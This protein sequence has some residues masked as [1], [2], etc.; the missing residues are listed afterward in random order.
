MIQSWNDCEQNAIWLWL[1]YET[2]L[3]QLWYDCDII[4]RWL[5][6]D[7]DMIMIWLWYDYDMI[8]ILIWNDYDIIMK[9]LWYDTSMIV[10]WLSFWYD[11]DMLMTA[12]WHDSWLWYA[13]HMLLLGWRSL[14]ESVSPLSSSQLAAFFSMERG[15]SF[16]LDVVSRVT[17]PPCLVNGMGASVESI[18]NISKCPL[19]VCRS[20][21]KSG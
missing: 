20:A 12:L 19:P 16:S 2:I 4:N 6:Y 1:N 5:W 3:K 9:C 14:W 7:Y 8:V 17:L 11:Y 15:N 18:Q 21:K 10:I 13:Y